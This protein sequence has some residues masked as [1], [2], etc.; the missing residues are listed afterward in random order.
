M[1]WP[2]SDIYG[3]EEFP[4]TYK[5]LVAEDDT[6]I[7]E[8]LRLYL[9]N[10]GFEVVSAYDGSEAYELMLSEKPDLA[11]LDIMMPVINGYELT[12]KIREIS[13]IPIIIL[14]AMNADSDKILGLDIGADDYITKPFNPL[15]VIA[16]IQSN[17]RRKYKLDSSAAE[18]NGDMLTVGELKLDTKKFILYKNGEEIMLTPTEFKI[19]SLFMEKPGMVFTKAQIYQRINGDFYETDDNTM[20]VHISKLRDKLG[21]NSKS[22]TYIKTVR[23]LGYKIEKK[24]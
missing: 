3:S 2:H 13:N 23:G 15:E 22:P 17:L 1:K 18:E 21:D 11:L 16:R 20:M 6:D 10:S 9:V 8:V 12:K 5:I 4:M 14:S 24:K 19:L 7:Q